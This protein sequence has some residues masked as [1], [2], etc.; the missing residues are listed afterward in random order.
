MDLISLKRIHQNHIH[1]DLNFFN[2]CYLV[3]NALNRK[4]KQFSGYDRYEYKIKRGWLRTDR[5]TNISDDT[6]FKEMSQ[7][8]LTSEK[9]QMSGYVERTKALYCLDE[10]MKTHKSTDKITGVGICV[11]GKTNIE[12]YFKNFNDFLAVEKFFPEELTMKKG[13]SFFLTCNLPKNSLMKGHEVKVVEVNVNGV[14]IKPNSV[15]DIEYDAI[16][17]KKSVRK[18]KINEVYLVK[19]HENKEMIF[20]REQYPL[21]YSWAQMIQSIIGL[22]VTKKI[23][24]DN[25]RSIQKGEAYAAASR[26]PTIDGFLLVHIPKNLEELNFHDFKCDEVGKKFEIWLQDSLKSNGLAATR[27]NIKVDFEGNVTTVLENIVTSALRKKR[28]YSWK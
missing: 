4:D 16:E 14:W 3:N 24:F 22:T 5:N 12:K 18:V 25:S 21:N 20:E 11:T 23:I 2:S 27:G 9:L 28:R 1:K 13:S 7:L 15:N 10:T 26:C 19:I 6:V 8:I 17:L